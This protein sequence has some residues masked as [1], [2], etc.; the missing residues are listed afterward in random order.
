MQTRCGAIFVAGRIRFLQRNS[1]LPAESNQ[2]ERIHFSCA[3]HFFRGNPLSLEE[4]ILLEKSDFSG[5]IRS[6]FEEPFSG[7][8]HSIIPELPV[9]CGEESRYRSESTPEQE[10]EASQGAPTL[11]P[12]SLT[13]QLSGPSE[14]LAWRSSLAA[15]ACYWG[16]PRAWYLQQAGRSEGGHGLPLTRVINPSSSRDGGIPRTVRLAFG[17][18]CRPPLFRT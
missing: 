2:P 11:P 10:R 7:G 12:C 4:S 6:I 8:R 15:D 16:S 18:A 9:S 3:I 5:E 13:P 17:A 1:I 14:T